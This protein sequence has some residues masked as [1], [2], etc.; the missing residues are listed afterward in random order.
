MKYIIILLF[1][2][3]ACSLDPIE[4]CMEYQID[5]GEIELTIVDPNPGSYY[6]LSINSVTTGI[7]NIQFPPGSN[8][9]IYPCIVNEYILFETDTNDTHTINDI[10]HNYYQGLYNSSHLINAC[11][12]TQ[13]N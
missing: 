6:Y 11:H 3:T 9:I 5:N 12:V 1:A 4:T 7:I 2:V 8:K 13:Q 10:S